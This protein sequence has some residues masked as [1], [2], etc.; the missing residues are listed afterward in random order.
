[1]WISSKRYLHRDVKTGVWPDIWVPQAYSNRHIK[2]TFTAV[3]KF[4]LSLLFQVSYIPSGRSRCTLWAKQKHMALS[5]FLDSY[6]P[7]Q[8]NWLHFPQSVSSILHTQTLYFILVSLLSYLFWIHPTFYVAVF[9]PF[10]GPC[11]QYFQWF[12]CGSLSYLIIL[13]PQGIKTDGVEVHDLRLPVSWYNN[14]GYKLQSQKQ[15]PNASICSLGY[16]PYQS[17][18]WQE[19][20]H[21]EFN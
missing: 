10:R 7:S 21:Q 16:L 20:A 8:E 17:G 2:L 19:T 1:M 5:Q 3:M 11:R 6:L 18:S 14:V 13:N 9:A 4:L 12:Q 15:K